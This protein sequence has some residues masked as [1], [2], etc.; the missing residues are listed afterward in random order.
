MRRHLLHINLLQMM[1]PSICI[2]PRRNM[3]KSTSA[4]WT[5]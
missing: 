3:K 4:V 2:R 1:V 5:R